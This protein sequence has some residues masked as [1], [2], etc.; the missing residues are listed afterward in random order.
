MS[1]VE[2][3]RDERGYGEENTRDYMK[4]WEEGQKR[5]TVIL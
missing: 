4:F 2:D 5:S 1:L 3:E